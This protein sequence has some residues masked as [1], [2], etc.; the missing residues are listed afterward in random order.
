MVGQD[1]RRTNAQFGKDAGMRTKLYKKNIRALVATLV[2]CA[3]VTFT[4]CGPQELQALITGIEAAAAVLANVDTGTQEVQ[5][6]ADLNFGE[7]FLS[8]LVN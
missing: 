8:E 6:N 7:W 3:P 2:G 5:V 4:S 1:S